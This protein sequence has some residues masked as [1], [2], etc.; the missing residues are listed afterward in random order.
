[1]LEDTSLQ[2]YWRPRANWKE[3]PACTPDPPFLMP[4]SWWSLKHLHPLVHRGHISLYCFFDLT[5]SLLPLSPLS[6]KSLFATP[7]LHSSAKSYSPYTGKFLSAISWSSLPAALLNW[8]SSCYKYN[9]QQPVSMAPRCK[10]PILL[11]YRNVI[12]RLLLSESAELSS[13]WLRHHTENW[14][15]ARSLHPAPG[16]L[17]T[18]TKNLQFHNCVSYWR[19]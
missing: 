4:H 18:A 6:T 7:G 3:S 17:L 5:A 14:Q 8:Q 16:S 15:Q 19:L 13:V 2:K 12:F 11:R 10:R 9:L 1:M